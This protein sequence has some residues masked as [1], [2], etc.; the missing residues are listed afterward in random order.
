MKAVLKWKT[1][2]HTICTHLVKESS[3]YKQSFF[4]FF[5]LEKQMCKFKELKISL[6][7]HVY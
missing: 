6:A 7:E 4:L 2:E 3:V 1:V 5:Y